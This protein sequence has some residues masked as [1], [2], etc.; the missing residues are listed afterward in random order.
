LEDTPV[1]ARVIKILP[2][3]LVALIFSLMLLSC[4]APSKNAKEPL[5]CIVAG[6]MQPAMEELGAH[7]EKATGEKVIF[8]F[9]DS[10]Q[11]LSK[12][13]T[14][15]KGDIYVAHDPYPRELIKKGYAAK[16]WNVASL[17]PVIVVAKGNPKKI[18]GL[19]DLA[20]PKLKIVLTE[21]ADSPLGNV[22]PRMA[23]K[24]GVWNKMQ[25]NLVNKARSGTETANA[26][27]SGAADAAVVWNS[28]ATLRA[29]KLD[30]IPIENEFLPM[31]V[32]D[33]AIGLTGERI[34]LGN[35]RIGVATLACSK[36]KT[37]A[38]AFAEFC[39]S[40]E[41]AETW[42]KFGFAPPA[43]ECTCE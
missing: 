26:V 3:I 9:L 17:S 25:P 13:E 43:G 39:A 35:V 38:N 24:A 30:I 14:T 27:E 4:G 33:F 10:G 32:V 40:A 23:E 2:L 29:D 16:C 15:K 22:L 7:F 20:K 21:Y 11:L 42:A 28:V 36:N 5:L 41:G 18:A 12:I 34:D 6:T 19:K 37:A 8:D 1:I 31:P